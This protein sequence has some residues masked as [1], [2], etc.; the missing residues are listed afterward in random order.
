ME[1]DI[2]WQVHDSH[3]VHIVLH[4]IHPLSSHCIRFHHTTHHI[5]QCHLILTSFYIML[6]HTMYLQNMQIFLDHTELQVLP[7]PPGVEVRLH[8]AGTAATS[9]L[10]PL[11]VLPIYIQRSF[12]WMTLHYSV[13]L[14]FEQQWCAIAMKLTVFV[15]VDHKIC[16]MGI[17]NLVMQPLLILASYY[18]QKW[19]EL[20]RWKTIFRSLQRRTA[21][22]RAMQVLCRQ[23]KLDDAKDRHRGF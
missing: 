3:Q 18:I 14:L 15:V 4:P 16:M 21:I 13:C 7:T 9:L 10:W 22:S 19:A 1:H 11:K 5:I 12:C 23:S 8:Q 17:C 20:G 6:H 2:F